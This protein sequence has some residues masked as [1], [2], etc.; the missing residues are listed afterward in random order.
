MRHFFTTTLLATVAAMSLAARASEV[1]GA[2]D[3]SDAAVRRQLSSSV[4]DLGASGA[5]SG[6]VIAARGTELIA[7]ASAGYADRAKKIP[8]TPSTRFTIGS[9]GKMFT[10]TAIGQL[11]DHGKLSYGSSSLTIRTTPCVA[12]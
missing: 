6:I 11:V 7:V 9:M 10:S 5:F 12:R 2:R 1:Q 8:I 4:A 3:L